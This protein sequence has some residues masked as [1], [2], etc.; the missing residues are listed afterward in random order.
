MIIIRKR[1][2]D[3]LK[4]EIERADESAKKTGFGLVLMYMSQQTRYTIAKLIEEHENMTENEKYAEAYT[5]GYQD[6]LGDV[7]RKIGGLKPHAGRDHA[8][9]RAD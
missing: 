1:D 7:R 8:E 3:S 5:L 6:A 2:I 9:K 4:N